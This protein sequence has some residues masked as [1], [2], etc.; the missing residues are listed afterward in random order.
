[1]GAP[2]VGIL[3]QRRP[4]STPLSKCEQMQFQMEFSKSRAACF[5][6]IVLPPRERWIPA[7]F[8]APIFS[9]D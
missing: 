1:M 4:E 6:T 8:P 9:I 2:E 5:S 7:P 3:I